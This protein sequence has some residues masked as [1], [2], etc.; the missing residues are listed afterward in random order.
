[1]IQKQMMMIVSLLMAA[2]AIVLATDEEQLA[3]VRLPYHTSA[4][5]G[6]G[7]VMELLSGHPQHICTELGVSHEVFI[8]LIDELHHMG[9]ADSKFVSLEEQVA[10]FLYASVTGLTSQHLG[11]RFQHTNE[12]ITKYSNYSFNI[13]NI[14]ADNCVLSNTIPSGLS[15]NVLRN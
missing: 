8:A 1:M 6:E 9:H 2:I 4:L 11:E 14:G 7:W 5:T 15:M 10:I 13:K 12:T 3:W